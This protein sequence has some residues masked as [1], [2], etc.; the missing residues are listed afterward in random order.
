MVTPS[1][2]HSLLEKEDKCDFVWI[3]CWILCIS[4]EID[5]ILRF[6]TNL[7]VYWHSVS[8][9]CAYIWSWLSGNFAN[10]QQNDDFCYILNGQ[11]GNF[12]KV[13]TFCCNLNWLQQNS[14]KSKFVLRLKWTNLVDPAL[15]YQLCGHVLLW[16]LFMNGVQL[17]QIF[18]RLHV[19]IKTC[20]FYQSKL[21]ILSDGLVI[22][23]TEWSC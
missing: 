19:E 3:Y 11:W 13:T 6:K 22:F 7:M 4:L 20:V 12:E 10:F 9:D 15:K 14:G 5:V 2:S 21:R 17:C 16:I 18:L 23:T 1:C 8:M